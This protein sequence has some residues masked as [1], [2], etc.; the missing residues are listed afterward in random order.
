MVSVFAGL[1]VYDVATRAKGGA[2]AVS[3]QGSTTGWSRV[4][5]F[6]LLLLAAMIAL[7]LEPR[8]S[9]NAV[10][11]RLGP[12]VS[13]RHAHAVNPRPVMKPPTPQC[14]AGQCIT[15]HPDVLAAVNA[16]RARRGWAPVTWG[17]NTAASACALDYKRCD[18]VQW[19]G[20]PIVPIAGEQYTATIGSAVSNGRYGCAE[21]ISFSSFVPAT[22]AISR[23][24]VEVRKPS[25]VPSTRLPGRT[26][27]RRPSAHVRPSV[28]TAVSVGA[29][30]PRMP[31]GHSVTMP[32]PVINRMDHRWDPT[33]S[34]R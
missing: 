15:G 17:D 30:P 31:V 22:A 8:C 14:L 13:L 6:G 1:I 34:A 4:V 5:R 3:L 26:S 20:C 12:D 11:S 16:A 29:A 10:G 33:V 21:A 2:F 23:P 28:T 24:S 32:R 27:A 9:A 18:G 7:V 19:G 25:P